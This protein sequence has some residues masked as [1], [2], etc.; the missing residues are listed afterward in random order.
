MIQLAKTV[1]EGIIDH[2]KK[3]TPIEACGYLGGKEGIISELYRMRNID[4]S[5]EHFAFDPKE[6]FSA[7][8]DAR[9]K[10]LSLLANYHS[11]PASPSRPSEEDIKLAFD[12]NIL[13]FIV[14]LEAEEPVLKAFRIQNGLVELVPYEIV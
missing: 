10:G 13:Y 4:A 12:P 8:R 11:H 2:A 9:S 14:S 1:Y 6:Q 5:P 3:E 7:M